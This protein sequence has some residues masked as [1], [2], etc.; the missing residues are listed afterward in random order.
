MIRI[1]QYASPAQGMLGAVR[2]PVF[3][4]AQAVGTQ[5]RMVRD[6]TERKN[7]AHLGALRQ[8]RLQIPIALLDLHGQRLVLRRQAL[9]RVGDACPNEFK[10]IVGTD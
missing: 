9:D 8:F 5:H 2:E 10:V 4:G 6:R 3:A 1:E 7:N